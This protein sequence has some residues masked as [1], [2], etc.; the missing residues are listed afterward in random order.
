MTAA[1]RTVITCSA[2]LL[3][4]MASAAGQIAA[5]A[6]N[7]EDGSF[8]LPPAGP[9][10]PS[11]PVAIAAGPDGALH[12]VDRLGQVMVFDRA[13]TPVRAYGLGSL[14]QP[15]AVAVD[16]FGRSYVLDKQLKQVLVYNEEGEVQ[17]IIAGGARG[18]SRLNDPVSLA[19]GPHGFLY[20]LDKGDKSVG[21]FSRDG[22]FVRQLRLGTVSQDLIGIAIGGDGRIFLVGDNRGALVF[23]LPAFSDIPWQGSG[24][25]RMLSLG[26]IEKGAAVAVDGSGMVVVLDGQQGRIWGGSRLDP[27]APTPSRALYGGVGGGR[28]S[29]RAP[30]G[31]AFTPERHL[32]VLDRDL[33]KVER[34]ELTE[35]VDALPLE[36]DYPIRVSQLPPDP[37]GAVTAV[38]PAGDGVAR[39][40]MVSAGSSMLRV[41]PATLGRYRDLSGDVFESYSVPEVSGPETWQMEFQ[42]TPGAVAINDTL[43]VV[44]EPDRNRFHVFDARD[45]E[46]LGEFGHDYGDDRRLKKPVGI[47]LF[48][49]G[50]L[51]VA[52]RDNHRIAIFSPDLTALLASFSVREAW[53]VAISPGGEL[54]AWPESGM[55]ILRIPLPDGPSE[56][57][58]YGLL[59]GGVQDIKFDAQGNLFILEKKT[60]RVTVLDSSLERVLVR[61]GGRDSRFEATHLS[62]DAWG[63]VYLANLAE[64]RS[65]VYRWD[66]RLPE[67]ETLRAIL[68]A[69]CVAFSWE[70]LDSDYMWGYRISGATTRQ[71]PFQ[72]LAT[73]TAEGFDLTLDEDFEYRWLRVDP[74]SITGSASSSDQP[75]PVAHWVVREAAARDGYSEVLEA[76]TSAESLSAEGVLSLAPD[77]AQEIQWFAFST[78][79]Q[80]GRYADAVAREEALEGWEGEDR[81]LEL[82]RLLA[83]AHSKLGQYG[84]ALVN[85]HRALEVLPMR[86]RAGEAGVEILQLGMTAAFET[87]AFG[88][89]GAFGEEL[90]GR[91]GPEREFQLFA[92]VAAA[93]LALNNLEGALQ[94]AMAVRTRDQAGQIEAYD[95]DR[96]DLYWVAVQASMALPDTTLM[97]AWAREYTPYLTD[98]RRRPYHEALA[99]FWA[100]QGQGAQALTNFQSLL[101]TTSEPEFYTDSATVDLTFGIFRA[102]QDEDT[103]S[104]QEG[105]TFLAGYAGD[106]PGEVEEL[107]L[108]Y[109][110]SIAVFE[111]RED[112]RLKLGEGFQHWDEANFA[113]LVG[114][115]EEAIGL[116]GLTLEQETI[117][118]ALLAG[119]Y[120]SAGRSEDAESTYRGI[121]DLDPLFDIDSMVARVEE[122]YGITVFDAQTTEVFRNVR[123]I[124]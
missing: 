21:V 1:L 95:E 84:P 59:G 49:D 96:Q 57:V 65:L 47:A 106:L 61:M 26:V 25:H 4:N 113:G 69:D 104:R 87:E 110:D 120:Q 112:T 102:L 73:T 35:G 23:A 70:A 3:V 121:L 80:V 99:H 82:H 50:S 123:R 103:E 108:A 66:A 88:E 109:L 63:N 97:K 107:R 29:F 77:V 11:V 13:G 74:V 62:V 6:T 118:R 116:G 5:R 45:G 64:G 19:F 54:F 16:E 34:I 100:S 86:E 22:A 89:V 39:F 51:A 124:R 37:V 71:G 81:G 18:A 111:P 58:A 101:E 93:R 85:V 42:R 105:L 31:L 114:F 94:I 17:F 32:V 9:T 78:E 91:V 68:S 53:G 79:F 2:L 40:V 72:A 15:V 117:S 115:F 43:L 10:S 67:L 90:Q 14:T 76:V 41:E 7:V 92:R 33:R 83:S 24:A 52:D 27:E 44:T 38:G 56:M 48:G 8:N 119:A 60:S 12:I 55:S 122:V 46:P 98:D 30:V 36:W 28:G 20:V 75:I